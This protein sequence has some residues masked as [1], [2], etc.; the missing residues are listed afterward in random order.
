MADVKSGMKQIILF[1]QI[2]GKSFSQSNRIIRH[3]ECLKL[4]CF[5]CQQIQ[6][7]KKETRSS[8]QQKHNG[9]GSWVCLAHYLQAKNSF[10]RCASRTDLWPDLT[11]QSPTKPNPL[12][13]QESDWYTLRRSQVPLLAGE[14]VLCV[15][16]TKIMH[17]WLYDE[18]SS[19]RCIHTI[20]KLE[21]ATPQNLF[22]AFEAYLIQ[23]RFSL[24]CEIP[25]MLTL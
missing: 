7:R 21:A 10:V 19:I 15:L 23:G 2:S 17:N 13:L 4:C 1:S 24:Y 16:W 9:R 11:D 12:Y 18:H 3:K 25:I 8:L 5:I 6:P 14:K 22:C 20:L